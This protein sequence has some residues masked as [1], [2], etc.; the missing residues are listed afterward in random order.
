[1][2]S[3]LNIMVVT[4]SIQPAPS[5]TFD[6]TQSLHTAAL[7]CSQVFLIADQDPATA[8][9]A[10]GTGSFPFGIWLPFHPQNSHV[11]VSE[12]PRRQVPVCHCLITCRANTEDNKVIP[13]LGGVD[14]TPVVLFV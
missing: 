8:K 6:E 2:R 7:S 1:M 13:P 10:I 11:L 12:A 9:T 4:C 14:V 3:R 5:D